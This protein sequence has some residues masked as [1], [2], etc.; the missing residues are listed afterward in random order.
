MG[1]I[2]ISFH[3]WVSEILKWCLIVCWRVC[4]FSGIVKEWKENH[5]GKKWLLLFP[6][7]MIILII[8]PD[9]ML[10]RQVTAYHP[11]TLLPGPWVHPGDWP[12]GRMVWTKFSS[13]PLKTWVSDHRC[14]DMV[15]SH[16]GLTA[17]A[18]GNKNLQVSRWFFPV[19]YD[20]WDT[21]RDCPS[22]PLWIEGKLIPPVW[23]KPHHFLLT[24]RHQR[25]SFPASQY[26]VLHRA[27]HN[28]SVTL[29]LCGFLTLADCFPCSCSAICGLQVK[30][31]SP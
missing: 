31:T 1:Y 12:W 7:L 26:A 28:L 8:G 18:E 15:R 3:W 11:T 20:L 30:A 21:L 9:V 16:G 24:F 17:V 14:Q 4:Y 23:E 10:C 27:K 25:E 29:S 5:L 6:R 19:S 2:H 22:L 13:I